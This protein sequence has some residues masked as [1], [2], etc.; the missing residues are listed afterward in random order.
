MLP[1]AMF[2]LKQRK[3]YLKQVQNLENQLLALEQQKVAL[4]GASISATVVNTM[5]TGAKAMKNIHAGMY[6]HQLS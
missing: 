5:S 1:A 3:M 6:V 2:A 4:E